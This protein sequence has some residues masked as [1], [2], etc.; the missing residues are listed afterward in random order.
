MRRRRPAGDRKWRGLGDRALEELLVER[1]LYRGLLL[2]IIVLTA[3]VTTVLG[4]RGVAGP[5]DQ[6]LVG[7]LVACALALGAV[8]WV[9]RLRDLEIHRELRR[10][11]LGPP[12]ADA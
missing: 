10:R 7:I 5:R 3:I 12:R 8:A 1:W 6:V 11:R 9:M 2:G 4:A